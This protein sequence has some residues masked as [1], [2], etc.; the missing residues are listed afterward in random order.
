MRS[1]RLTAR[2]VLAALLGA[3]PGCGLLLDL[4]PARDGST[5]TLDAGA[6]D[7]AGDAG[8]GPMERCAG[9]A[10][11]DGDGAIDCDDPDCALDAACPDP[12]DGADDD[13][14]GRIDEGVDGCPTVTPGEVTIEVTVAAPSRDLHL[15]LDRT[16][17]MVTV[18]SALA[19]DLPGLVSGAGGL[20]EAGIGVSWFA[21]FP[22]AAHGASG[23]TPY[24]LGLRITTGVGV[25]EVAEILRGI[26]PGVGSDRSE[27]GI[28]ALRQIATGAGVSWGGPN[29]G[30]VPAMDCAAGFDAS[31]GHGT[32]G[33]AC[34]RE[35]AEPVIFHLTDAASHDAD[36]YADDG[37]VGPANAA[38]T[39]AALRGLG[40][41][42]VGLWAGLPPP[43]ASLG[44]PRYPSGMALETGTAVPVCAWDGER[45]RVDG[46]CAAD[47]CCTGVDEGG[48]DP[49][50]AGRCPLAFELDY[51]APEA[52]ARATTAL[53]LLDRF[54]RRRIALEAVDGAGGT[55][56]A[57][58]FVSSVQV[59]DVEGPSDGCAPTPRAVDTDGD[60]T[61][62]AVDDATVGTTMTFTVRLSGT[63]DGT[64]CGT[65]G[66]HRLHLRALADARYPQA[67]RDVTVVVD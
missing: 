21:D 1:A 17:S 64:P 41:R 59:G 35:D 57:T 50:A 39:L 47:A 61:P 65:R 7:A 4:E 36:A 53:S 43:E 56:D 22:V 26:P 63:D 13:G 3:V 27:S 38:D 67:S 62:D 20:P 5:P 2:L 54:T 28:E 31:L 66:P 49:T 51:A 15:N 46:R 25:G 23:D 29:A 32:R 48:V 58:C 45:P 9:G 8:D 40:A 10:D 18:L 37:V 24:D 60:G 44:D 16:G 33:G 12:C 52:A 42:V 11:E 30:A 19:D 14:D 55:A 34:F 6:P